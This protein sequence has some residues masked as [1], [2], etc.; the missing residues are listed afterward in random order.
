MKVSK[1]IVSQ[2]DDEILEKLLILLAKSQ[3]K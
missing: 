2:E 1:I 3:K